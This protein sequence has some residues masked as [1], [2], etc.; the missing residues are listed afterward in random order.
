MI[1]MTKGGLR[2]PG[3]RSGPCAGT[4]ERSAAAWSTLSGT[5]YLIR[6]EEEEG[7]L[8]RAR[9]DCDIQDFLGQLSESMRS[10]A[11]SA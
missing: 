6:G 7:E 1:G 8:L 9:A 4:G 2:R 10:Q 3:R 11:P 5:I